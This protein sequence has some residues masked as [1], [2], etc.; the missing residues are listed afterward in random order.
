[1]VARGASF[2]G[3]AGELGS[4][5]A[6]YARTAEA[7]PAWVLIGG[8]PGI[9]KSRLVAEFLSQSV[10]SGARVLTGGAPIAGQELPFAPFLAA[11]RGTLRAPLDSQLAV[12][13]AP[14]IPVLAT[15][16]P[17]LG[18]AATADGPEVEA[19]ELGRARLFEA[20]LELIESLVAIEPPLVLVLEDLH[21]ADRSSLDLLAFLV[22][23][24]D[25]RPFLGI[26]T[27]RDDV[28][29]DHRIRGLVTELAR[30]ER[31]EHLHLQALD[32]EEGLRLLAAGLAKGESAAER[33]RT[34]MRA[35]GNPLFIQELASGASDT[36]SAQTALREIIEARWS[37][38]PPPARNV[39]RIAAAAG[40]RID[41]ELLASA[42]GLP[43]SAVLDAIR[44][45]E[46][47]R[48]LE[49][50]S[51]RSYARFRHAVIQEVVYG[52]LAAP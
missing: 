49:S 25:A 42:T 15:L 17:A 46:E 20:I 3:R 32:M 35:G 18:N 12:R 47:R 27:Y 10:P 30:S 16:F 21:W 38:I 2:V 1:M 13:I 28:E 43:A 6:A 8:E 29:Q 23:N 39:L 24:L 36:G 33:R 22:R 14:V 34:V 44:S 9:G 50:S 51:D 31:V 4:L 5:A 19:A 52:M 40:S 7:G 45:G 48:I 11:F 41:P 26:V 37:Q